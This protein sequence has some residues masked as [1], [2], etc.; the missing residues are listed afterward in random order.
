MHPNYLERQGLIIRGYRWP[1]AVWPSLR[2]RAWYLGADAVPDHVDEFTGPP[3]DLEM[4]A[5]ARR[6]TL[7]LQA[8]D[9]DHLNAVAEA[10]YLSH[11][12]QPIAE[13]LVAL[14]ARGNA[15]SH[16]VTVET[17][18]DAANAISLGRRFAFV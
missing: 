2:F 15:N 1:A 16:V 5:A 6:A 13:V 14:M 4:I 10:V 8:R 9:R 3:I 7:E 18:V 11:A 12:G 17:L